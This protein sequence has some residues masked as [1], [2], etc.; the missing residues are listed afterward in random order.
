[1]FIKPTNSI[2]DIKS[3]KD[4][5]FHLTSRSTKQRNL[6]F[7]GYNIQRYTEIFCWK[8]GEESAGGVEVYGFN[9]SSQDDG[10]SNELVRINTDT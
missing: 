10:R 8:G 1:M 2:D 9:K 4:P 6:V 7:G 5:N 3:K